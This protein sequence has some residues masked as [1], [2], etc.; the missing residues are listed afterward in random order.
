MC[1][2]NRPYYK[3]LREGSLDA[4]GIVSIHTRTMTVTIVH[5]D[6]HCGVRHGRVIGLRRVVDSAGM[7]LMLL[8]LLHRKVAS[9]GIYKE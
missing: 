7:M 5:R 4:G 6:S 1:I 9:L 2:H 3:I 8:L